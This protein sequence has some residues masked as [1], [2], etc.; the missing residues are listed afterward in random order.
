MLQDLHIKGMADAGAELTTK[1]DSQGIGLLQDSHTKGMA[2]EA[3]EV[4]AGEAYSQNIAS[5]KAVIEENTAKFESTA[6]AP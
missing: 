2:G 4:E 6:R 5:T 1:P 3:V